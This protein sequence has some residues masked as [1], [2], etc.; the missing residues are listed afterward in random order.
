L[1]EKKQGKTIT[2]RIDG[3]IIDKLDSQAQKREITLNRFVNQILKNFLEWDMLQSQAGMIPIAKPVLSEV[4]CKM[5]Q[6]EVI[7]LANQVGK[8]TMHDTILYMKQKIDVV[9]FLSWLETWLKKNSTSGFSHTKENDTDI[10]IMKH[11]LGENWSL[12]HKTVLH[13]IFNEILHRPID[14]TANKDTLV[15]K[16]RD[17]EMKK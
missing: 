11:D 4:F 3:D 10:C 13:E 15:F 12:Y 1:L 17:Y 5:D 6:Q 14:I 2:F 9:S 7:N 16:I 8:K